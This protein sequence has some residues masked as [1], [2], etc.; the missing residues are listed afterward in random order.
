MLSCAID[1]SLNWVEGKKSMW[2][3]CTHNKIATEPLQ[4]S[5]VSG[6]LISD[7]GRF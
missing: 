3:L 6:K 5:F 7:T 1:E 2:K 4:P